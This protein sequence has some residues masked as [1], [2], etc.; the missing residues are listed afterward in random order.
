MKTMNMPDSPYTLYSLA[1]QKT[2]RDY[3]SVETR[4]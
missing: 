2:N 1:K 3:A 4:A